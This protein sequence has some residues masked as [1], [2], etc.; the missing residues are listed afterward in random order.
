MNKL[1][2]LLFVL[3]L[4]VSA[5]EGRIMRFPNASETQ[6]TFSHGGDIYVA[7][8]NG[9]IARRVTSSEGYEMFPRFSPDGKTIAFS[10]EYDGNR[11][12]YTMPS[13]GGNPQRLTY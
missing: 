3:T 10:A 7:P 2:I 8:I 9:G 12:I 11:E 1:I 5:E 6:I 13:D 4:S